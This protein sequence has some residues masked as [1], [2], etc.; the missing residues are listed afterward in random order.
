MN[1]RYWP[2]IAWFFFWRIW[3]AAAAATVSHMFKMG[4]PHRLIEVVGQIIGLDYASDACF[5]TGWKPRPIDPSD[6]VINREQQP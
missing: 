1:I 6:L 5:L 3:F 2:V 4:L